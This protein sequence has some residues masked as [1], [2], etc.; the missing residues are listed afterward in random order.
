MNKEKIKKNL[1]VEVAILLILIIVLIIVACHDYSERPGILTAEEI[2][3]INRTA[4]TIT[5]EWDNNRNTEVYNIYFKK[6]GKEYKEWNKQVLED[7]EGNNK[8]TFKIKGLDEGTTYSVIVRADSEDRKGF[9]T[10]VM[11]YSTKNTQEIKSKDNITKLATSKDFKIKAKAKTKVKY[12]SDNKDIAT[13]NEKSGKVEIKKPGTVTIK[14]VASGN[15]RYIKA[16]KKIKLLVLDTKT[17]NSCAHIAYTLTTEN[18]KIVKKVKGDGGIHVPQGLAYT[19]DRYIIAYGM[20]SAQR[21]ISFDVKG[22]KK[23]ISVPKIS[24]G[25]PNGFTY[26]EKTGLCYSVKGWSTGAVTYNPKT[27]EYGRTS[28]SYGCSGIAY[29]RKDKCFYTSSRTGMRKYSGD[30]NFTHK[31]YVGRMSH[32][33]AVY[34]QDC[35]GH[36]GIMFH[37][38]SGSSKHGTNYIDL[39]DMRNSKYIGTLK[40]QLSEVESAVVD[41]DGYLEV[42]SNVSSKTDY[43]YKTPINIEDIAEGL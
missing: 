9:S 15:N 27:G 6:K 23:S 10:D 36:A 33:G 37:C 5:L 7:H 16:S 19:G 21:I 31:S 29:D 4:N 13:V 28:L 30:G 22:K 18:C 42:L 8:E 3:A 26:S 40:C 25:H 24:L 35:G 34:T 32:S 11:N 14:L 41:E 2:R 17:S 39:Y 43:I 20:S 1:I 38:M 12:S